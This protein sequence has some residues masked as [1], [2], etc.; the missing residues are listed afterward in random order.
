MGARNSA[1]SSRYSHLVQVARG[2]QWW[3]H[4]DRL[5]STND[6]PKTNY[7]A[8]VIP[9]HETV[10][11]TCSLEAEVFPES[12]S[13]DSTPE[14]TESPVKTHD[15]ECEQTTASS[16]AVPGQDPALLTSDSPTKSLPRIYPFRK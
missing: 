13:V 8:L 6:S 1:L 3:Q 5:L 2:I 10:K 11:P 14:K 16:S 4:V 9:E 15:R 7:P 12:S